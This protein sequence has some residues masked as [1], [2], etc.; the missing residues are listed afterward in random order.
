PGTGCVPGTS[1]SHGS[2]LA[3]LVVELE[4][5]DDRLIVLGFGSYEFL[6]LAVRKS[7]KASLVLLRHVEESLFDVGLQLVRQGAEN[8]ERAL[9]KEVRLEDDAE[10]VLR[11]FLAVGIL[12]NAAADHA[13]QVGIVFRVP[14]VGSG[15]GGALRQ[16][17]NCVFM[18]A[19]EE[20]L[21]EERIDAIAF[22]VEEEARRIVARSRVR[23]D[24]SNGLALQ[25]VHLLVRAVGA[26]INDRI[27]AVD[28]GIVTLVDERRG[29]D[30]GHDGAGVGRRAIECDLDV[31]G[32][33]AFDN[34]CIVVG[35]AQRYL[36]A[37]FLAEIGSERRIA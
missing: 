14:G 22:A 2:G 20:V 7:I 9:R 35:D 31:T 6:I 19:S 30:A 15:I 4:H 10:V 16:S 12:Q 29:F 32:A 23:I 18:A 37:E 33:L 25:V 21:T 11:Q 24:E 13:G 27:I 28:A 17:E 8:S 3:S 5:F 36:G 1:I 34:G 26:N